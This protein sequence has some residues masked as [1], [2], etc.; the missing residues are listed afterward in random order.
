MEKEKL[1]ERIYSRRKVLEN[2]CVEWTGS[3]K[4]VTR[5]KK[6]R[7]GQCWFDGKLWLAHRF[8]WIREKG[9]VPEGLELDHICRNSLCVNLAHLRAVT[10]RE[11]TRNRAS[12]DPHPCKRCG[13]ER[14]DN[15]KG[16][17]I[18]LKCRVLNVKAW[19][20][21]NKARYL[22][23]SRQSYARCKGVPRN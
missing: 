17:K 5:D 3:T 20:I 18:C 6:Y 4:Y 23:I 9:E 21:N 7:Y 10:H 8:F 1:L 13:G 16:H 2:G 11:N 12:S 22:E 19:R 14:V 15:V